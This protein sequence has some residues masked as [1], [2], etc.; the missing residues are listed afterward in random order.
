VHP[1]RS[2]TERLQEVYAS[3]CHLK[4]EEGKEEMDTLAKQTG[5]SVLDV[6]C[7]ASLEPQLAQS[8]LPTTTTDL[9]SFASAQSKTDVMIDD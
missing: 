9:L 5:Q 2:L 6:L 7:A 1:W 8:T 4:T 3:V